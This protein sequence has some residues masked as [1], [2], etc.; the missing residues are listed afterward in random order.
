MN[1]ISDQYIYYRQTLYTQTRIYIENIE[2][3]HFLFLQ[4][5]VEKYM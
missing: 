4:N 1:I 2:T 3:L 5:L